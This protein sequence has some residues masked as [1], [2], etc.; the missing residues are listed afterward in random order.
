VQAEKQASEDRP[1]PDED[2]GTKK[3]EVEEATGESLENPAA[4]E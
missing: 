4:E 2:G 3:D 1:N